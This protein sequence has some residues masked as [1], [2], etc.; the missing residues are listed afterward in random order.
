MPGQPGADL[1][2]PLTKSTNPTPIRIGKKAV[3]IRPDAE[4]WGGDTIFAR[5]QP[6]NGQGVEALLELIL[7]QAEVLELKANPN[8]RLRR[9]I[10]ARLDKAGDR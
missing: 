4:D 1:S 5:F 9:I 3:A 6:K 8:K 7:L 10:E 2:W